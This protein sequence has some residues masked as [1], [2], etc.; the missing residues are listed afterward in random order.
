M[1]TNQVIRI[2]VTDDGDAHWT[3][4][5]RLALENDDG[6]TTEAFT[7]YAQSITATEPDSDS[8]LGILI[9]QLR[10][11]ASAAGENANREMSITDTGWGGHD[12]KPY[13]EVVESTAST[14][15]DVDEVGV[16]TYTFTWTNFATVDGDRVHFG[17][18]LETES[19]DY[20]ISTLSN[21]QRLV[22]ESPDNYGLDTPTQLTWNGP[23]EFSENELEIVFL[24]GA[25]P[26]TGIWGLIADGPV[27]AVIALLGILAIAVLGWVAS[28]N[29]ETWDE[30]RSSL[31]A[32]LSFERGE[33]PDG[34]P[35]VAA[36]SNAVRGDTEPQRELA[37][38]APL[39]GQGAQFE[40]SERV[41]ED[42]DP[43]LLSD[44]ERVQRMLTRNGGRMKQAAI[45]SETGW[46][47]A[48]VSQL[49][50]QMDEDDQIEKLRIGRENLITL[51]EVDPTE[52]D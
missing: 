26:G 30:V 12:V 2:N 41:N 50:S 7:E 22:I 42:I 51:P 48:K 24:R 33:D 35:G 9:Q 36:D 6:V 32:V 45:V 15:G 39:E 8:D 5:Y 47:N 43:E 17:E 4:E 20:V 25:Q 14:S 10:Q 31:E 52:I 1:G 11:Q 13:D 38:D 3:I 18:A 21:G 34:E 28:R 40:F 44:E 27:L 46:S 29:V 23:H 19:N 49:L 16:I 37:A